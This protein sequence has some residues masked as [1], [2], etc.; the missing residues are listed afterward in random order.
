MMARNLG[1]VVTRLIEA[2]APATRMIWV[3]DRGGDAIPDRSGRVR[4][5][6]VRS[7]PEEALPPA[8]V[9]IVDVD[10]RDPA[11]VTEVRR[12]MKGMPGATRKIMAVERGSR[13]SMVQ[14]YGL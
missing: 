6:D 13:V 10:L 14:A 12:L 9:L 3:T 1:C 8:D 11:I 4:H 7:L 2:D 5:I